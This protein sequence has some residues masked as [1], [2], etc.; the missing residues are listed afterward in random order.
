MALPYEDL[1]AGVEW[2]DSQGNSATDPN[3]AEGDATAKPKKSPEPEDKKA[4]S[5][6]STTQSAAL[7][8][9]TRSAGAAD[10]DDEESKGKPQG[11]AK[12]KN[13]ICLRRPPTRDARSPTRGTSDAGTPRSQSQQSGE[14]GGTP[15]EKKP[16]PK[17]LWRPKK[18]YEKE[19]L[20][21]EEKE[22]EERKKRIAE[23]G[24]RMPLPKQP[25]VPNDHKPSFKTP[26]YG[27]SWSTKLPDIVD[28]SFV[29]AKDPEEVEKITE[30]MYHS[31]PKRKPPPTAPPPEP[32]ADEELDAI[33]GR[34]T[35]PKRRYDEEAEEKPKYQVIE[36]LKYEEEDLDRVIQRLSTPRQVKEKPFVSS[37]TKSPR[38]SPDRVRATNERLY[39]ASYYDK[40]QEKWLQKTGGIQMD[41]FRGSQRLVEEE[42]ERRH[43]P[44][45]QY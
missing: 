28:L 8:D 24:S 13:K 3:K 33:I 29:P 20:E 27:T 31:H 12:P 30:K 37:T 6:R 15:R 41:G 18:D 45:L 36:P 43:S 34:L 9:T 38:L 4:A 17:R 40:L 1:M 10:D 42:F 16:F 44:K 19:R 26:M 23:Q 32:V 25:V 21:K 5:A 7:S 39:D 2:K 35:K 11:P 14:E 22:I